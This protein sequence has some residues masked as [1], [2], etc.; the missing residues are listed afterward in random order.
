NTDFDGYAHLR[1]HCGIPLAMGE[2]EFD[3][4]ALRELMARNA[5]DIW[6]PDILRLGGIEGWRGS[7]LQAQSHGIRVQPHYYK[8]YDVPLL[9][10]VPNGY[11]CESF[12][13]IDDLMDKPMEI[14]EGFAMPSAIPGWG[15]RFKD[16]FLT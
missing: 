11:C 16:D 2:R 5:I 9:C 1:L 15:F 14:R 13:W 3:T 4:T 6:Q 12:D 10:T 7:A 8:E